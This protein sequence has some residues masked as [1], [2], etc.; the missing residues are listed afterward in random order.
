MHQRHEQLMKPGLGAY[1]CQHIMVNPIW[2][3]S[4]SLRYM[5]NL[6]FWMLMVSLEITVIVSKRPHLF[7]ASHTQMHNTGSSNLSFRN[8]YARILWSPPWVP[9]RGY[10]LVKHQLQ[11][12][13]TSKYFHFADCPPND[14]RFASSVWLSAKAHKCSKGGSKQNW[15]SA[16]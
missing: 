5:Q 10:G 6:K 11:E 3:P 13:H 4:I 15:F 16:Q 9:R 14:A 8:E 7:N 2:K 12:L 1:N